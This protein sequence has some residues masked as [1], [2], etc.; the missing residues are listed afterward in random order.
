MFSQQDGRKYT[1]GDEGELKRRVMSV[2][3]R[4]ERVLFTVPSGATMEAG[5]NA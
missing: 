2:I 5:A 3:I 4:W 1:I